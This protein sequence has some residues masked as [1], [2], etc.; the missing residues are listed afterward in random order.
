MTTRFARYAVWFL[1]IGL[2]A[3]AT[4]AWATASIGYAKF[5]YGKAWFHEVKADLNSLNV[6]TETMHRPGTNSFWQVVRPAPPTVAVTGTFFG[7]AGGFP[8][9]D[10]LVDGILVAQ[11]QRGSVIAADWTGHV[12]IFDTRFHQ[13]VDWSRYRYAL[14]GTV[15]L[16]TRSKVMPDPKAQRF[17]DPRIW[18]RASRVAA[19]LRKDGKLVLVATTHSVTLRQLGYAMRSRGV[20]DAV[21]LDGGSST[22]LYY[23]G[24][25]IVAP[26]RRVSNLLV[27]R[28]GPMMGPAQLT[29]FAPNSFNPGPF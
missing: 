28:E 12:N 15:R 14:R 24:R 9:A 11:G 29:A 17:R 1:L 27:L 6:S 18:G 22:L 23:R 16:I 2:F 13:R 19:G 4:N 5:K 20:V 10:V 8:V 25:L 7:A 3:G 26:K 21:N